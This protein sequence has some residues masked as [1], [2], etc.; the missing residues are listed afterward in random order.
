MI[1]RIRIWLRQRAADAAHGVRE[2]VRRPLRKLVEIAL[3]DLDLM[4]RVGDLT[5]SVAFER[6]YLSEAASFKGRIPLYRW[7]LGQVAGA[8]GLFLEFGVYKGDS[9]N[10]LA[11]L[12]PD[13]TWYGFDSFVGL[14]EAWTLG[15]KAGAFS[16][17]GT[18]PDVRENVRLV[19]GFFQDT[20]PAFVA[21][22]RASS[23]A[24]LH[25]DAD[26]YSSTRTILENLKGLLVPGSIIIFD[27]LINYPGWQDGEYRAFM[28]YVDQNGVAFEYIGY[29]RTGSQVAVKL[30]RTASVT[31][32]ASSEPHLRYAAGLAPTTP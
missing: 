27:E 20:L 9:I 8:D 18:R 2:L 4:A 14:P 11:E 21:Q 31:P 28:E 10:R 26:L 29:N 30:T 1:A 6:A 13:V 12:K 25:V 15:A 3:S 32:A 24:V 22:Q 5:S 7:V 23:V 17:Q 16:T 19:E